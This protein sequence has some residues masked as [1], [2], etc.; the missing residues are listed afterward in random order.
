M[1]RAKVSCPPLAQNCA[2]C[3]RKGCQWVSVNN[4]I[5]LC[6]QCS[7]LHRELGVRV[8]FIQSVN[9]EWTDSQKMYMK[10]G[11]NERFLSVLAKYNLTDQELATKYT[12]RVMEW[13]RRVLKAEVD[14]DEVPMAPETE[15]MTGEMAEEVKDESSWV[16]SLLSKVKENGKSMKSK[17]VTVYDKVVEKSIETSSTFI[18]K[19]K[20]IYRQSSDLIQHN[21][22]WEYGEKTI[23]KLLNNQDDHEPVQ[24]APPSNN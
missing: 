19:S 24:K 11:G 20:N 12:S 17:V 16:S 4:G 6:S 3:S 7:E 8:S 15:E 23:E 2:D 10:G 18:D 1:S 14:G 21:P 13:Y 22:V 5:F 9:F